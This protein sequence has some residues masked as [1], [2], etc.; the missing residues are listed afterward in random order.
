MFF[1]CPH[2]RELVTTDRETRLPPPMCP[3]CGG[4]L[5]EQQAHVTT[6]AHAAPDEASESG[7]RS[8]ASFLRSDEAVEVRLAEPVIEAE[9]AG[10]DPVGGAPVA[11]AIDPMRQPA[12]SLQED[13]PISAAHDRSD[14]VDLLSIPPEIVASPSTTGAQSPAP[15]SAPNFTRHTARRSL[16]PR[17]ARWQWAA[18][19]V[20]SLT[21]VV[22]VLIADRAKLATDADWRPLITRMCATLGCSVPAWHQPGAFTMLNRNVRPIPGTGGLQVNATFRN[23]ARWAQPFPVLALS[24]SDADGRTLGARDFSASEYL[25]AAATQTQLDAGQSAQ[26]TLQLHEP[27]PDVVAFA[28]DFR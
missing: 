9:K 18:L 10:D 1:S 25:G 7:N 11:D 8:F 20:L 21:L 23:D 12:E 26:I 15:V 13:A 14:E 17:T 24:L 4:V 16:A 27:D 3:R 28:F 6:A 5:R 22:Q 19:I 2:C